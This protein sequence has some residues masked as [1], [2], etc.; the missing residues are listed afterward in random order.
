MA[1]LMPCPSGI[2]ADTAVTG[3]VDSTPGDSAMIIGFMACALGT[4]ISIGIASKV[5]TTEVV[6]EVID[7][8]AAIRAFQTPIP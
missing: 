4:P 5:I 2:Y 3:A 7:S 8:A 6:R 1:N